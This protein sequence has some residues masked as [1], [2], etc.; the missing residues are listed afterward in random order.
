MLPLGVV[1]PGASYWLRSVGGTVGVGVGVGVGVAV[2]VTVSCGVSGS[3]VTDTSFPPQ[4]A[5]STRGTTTR[6]RRTERAWHSGS[7]GACGLPFDAT[8]G[9]EHPVGMDLTLPLHPLHSLL[10][11]DEPFTPAMARDVG[12]SRAALERH[13]R[14]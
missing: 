13:V 3:A 5:R 14:D 10:P 4:A 7:V 6:R 2:T 11:L 1:S 8:P 12:I 9:P